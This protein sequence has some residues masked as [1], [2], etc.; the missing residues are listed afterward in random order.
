MSQDFRH[1]VFDLTTRV[2]EGHKVTRDEA[3]RL[4]AADGADHMDLFAGANRIREACA[5]TVVH[6]CSIVNIKSG[7]CSENCS[8]CSQS[9]HFDSNVPEYDLVGREEIDR[10][11]Q[12]A[13]ESGAHALGLVAAWRG[14]KK[15]QRL[16][17]LLE[18]IREA[19]SEGDLHVDASLGIVDDPEVA[20][21]LAEAGVHTYNHNLET[22]R[23]HFGA[24]CD[25]HDYD[26]RI[27]TLE[28]MKEAGIRRCS[29][30][31]FNLGESVE[32]RVDLALTLRDLGVEVVPLNFLNPM[33]GTPMEGRPLLEPLECLKIIAVFRFVMPDREIMVA[34]G[35]EVNLREL[36]SMMF[37]AGANFT[38]AGNYLTS[39]GRDSAADLQL[40]ADSGLDCHQAPAVK[41]NGKASLQVLQG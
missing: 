38:M 37:F 12:R 20:Q 3:L 14:L 24:I 13:R 17:N 18:R 10:E 9:A 7:R 4:M 16:D 35:R 36:Q 26:E 40:I 19:R 15:G 21:A 34:G 8:F 23:N 1:F 6:L 5:G 25:S 31:I 22:S 29:G 27:R 39:A 32:D 41:S 11:M 2:R 30:G 28:L 33:P